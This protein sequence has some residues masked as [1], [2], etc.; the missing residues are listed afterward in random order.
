MSNAEIIKSC[1]DQ[2][3]EKFENA[4]GIQALSNGEVTVNQYAGLM[5][6]IYYQ[7]RENPQIQVY[8]TAFFRG[9]QRE[10]VRGFLQHATAEIGHDQ[11]AL[12]DLGALG[13]D[14]ESMPSMNPAPSTIALT[15]FAYYQISQLNPI[16]YLGY[17]YFLEFMPTSA[18]KRYA[19]ALLKA[20]VPAEAMS[21][22][23]EHVTVDA[24]H[25]RL[26]QKYIDSLVVTNDDLQAVCYAIQVT[27]YLYANMLEQS[28]FDSTITQGWGVSG[29]ESIRLATAV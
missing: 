15:S 21:F 10:S 4:P 14:T 26:M 29:Q 16:G 23:M 3:L 11:L 8:A 25:N 1:F 6:Q 19:K 22:L 5:G 9:S 20:G 28:M 12:N 17:L 24:A 7:A 18:G 27:G 13:F 2:A